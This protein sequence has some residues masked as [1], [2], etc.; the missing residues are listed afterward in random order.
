MNATKQNRIYKTD[1]KIFSMFSLQEIYTKPHK[2][3]LY[4]EQLYV[5]EA[6]RL[7]NNII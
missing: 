1:G 7:E 4:K 2:E 6:Y 5:K 3:T